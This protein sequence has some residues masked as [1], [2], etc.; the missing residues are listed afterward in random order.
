MQTSTQPTVA[1]VDNGVIKAISVGNAKIKAKTNNEKEAICIVTVSPLT[2]INVSE[3]GT[4]NCYIIPSREGYRFNASVKGCTQNTV[5]N[6]VKAEVLWETFGTDSVPNVGEVVSDV[7]FVDGEVFFTSG[8]NGNAVIAVKSADNVI[9]WSWHI[10][11]SEGYNA[12][13]HGLSYKNDSGTMMDRN[14]GALTAAKGDN[15]SLGLLYQWGRK[16]PFPAT[17]DKTQTS[18]ALTTITWPTPVYDEAVLE[19]DEAVTG[20]TS[21]YQ[22]QHPMTFIIFRSAQKTKGS[23]WTPEKSESDPCPYGWKVP[24]DIWSKAMGYNKELYDTGLW[25][26]TNYG[27]DGQEL[28]GI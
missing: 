9:L 13:E 14:L 17:A 12:N 20:E 27:I 6:P 3:S 4:A 7:K 28:F 24:N 25:D 5:G 22:V 23:V 18:P 21:V 10:W 1:S 19:S 2:Y 15:L 16:D 26:S 8:K 11:V